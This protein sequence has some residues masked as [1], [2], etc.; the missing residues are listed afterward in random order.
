MFT[1]DL[2]VQNEIANINFTFSSA[3]RELIKKIV[4]IEQ[5]KKYSTDQKTF[6]T[7]TAPTKG[8]FNFNFYSFKTITKI[9]IY[10]YILIHI[11]VLQ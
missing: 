4:V 10:A 8:N 11:I 2:R 7:P 6:G 5:R 3:I 1:A 9:L